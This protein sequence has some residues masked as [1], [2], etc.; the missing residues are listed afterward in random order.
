MLLVVASVATTWAVEPQESTIGHQLEEMRALDSVLSERASDSER[1]RWLAEFYRA[2]FAGLQAPDVRAAMS[3][4]DL[5]ALTLAAQLAVFYHDD[6]DIL[7]DVIT[8]L[9]L[10]EDR[11]AALPGDIRAT[12]ELLVAGRRFE[13]ARHFLAVHQGL[14]E[15]E[16]PLLLGLR[17]DVK[18]AAEMRVGEAEGTLVWA[19]V[20]VARLPRILVIGHPLCHFTQDAARA[21]EADPELRALFAAHAKW[22]APQDTGTDFTVFRRWNTEHP[23]LPITI[24]Y[25]G[26]GFPMIDDWSTP[27]FYFMDQGRVV[28]Q[29][30]GW[31]Q[32]G[33]RD[34]ILTA[35]REAFPEA[36]RSSDR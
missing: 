29:V 8:D 31:P 35:Y 32:G 14:G 27:T 22:L 33:R 17:P 25:R 2:R 15:A 13:Q 16:P 23:D 20:D 10:L 30:A 5:R 12:Y 34:E 3:D 4:E 36:S 6:D 26:A 1:F 18:G 11:G 7:D 24:A 19:P 28:S 9:R 21:I